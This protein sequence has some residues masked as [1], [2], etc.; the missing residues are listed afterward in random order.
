MCATKKRRANPLSPL[1]TLSYFLIGY[2][3]ILLVKEIHFINYCG[4][5]LG[6]EIG[7]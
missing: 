2:S 4:E 6:G 5:K 7:G 3:T 1:A